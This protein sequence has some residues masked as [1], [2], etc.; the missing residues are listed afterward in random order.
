MQEENVVCICGSTRFKSKMMDVAERMTME[1][2]VVLMPN[3]FGHADDIDLSE[4]DKEKLDELHKVKIRMA[5]RVVVVN[6]DGY[7]GESTSEEI[8]FAEDI[9]RPVEYMETP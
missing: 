9:G 2:W 1:G 6:P 5:D 8:K 7:I 4:E 3:V